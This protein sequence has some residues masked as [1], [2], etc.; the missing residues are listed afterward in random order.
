MSKFLF[1]CDEANHVCDKNQYKEATFWEKVKLN[2]HLIGCAA[3]RK[4]SS[5]NTKLSKLLRKKKVAPLDASSKAQ[6]K[7]NFEK[8]LEKIKH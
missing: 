2:I 6:I 8:E 1:S 3:C 7:L 5:T 4:Y